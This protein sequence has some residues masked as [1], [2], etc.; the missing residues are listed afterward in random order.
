MN[1]NNQLYVAPTDIPGALDALQV[2]AASDILAF[3][4]EFD[5]EQYTYGFTLCLLQLA[6]PEIVVLI[7][8][9]VDNL[10]P[11]FMQLL[12]QSKAIKL[13]H[14]A[15]EDIRLLHALGVFPEQFE[16]TEIYARW[17]N[18]ENTSLSA[19]LQTYCG[20]ALDKDQQRSN[21]TKRPLSEKQL[22]YAQQDVVHL[23]GLRS[24]LREALEGKGLLQL[25]EE[26]IAVQAQW[27]YDETPAYPFVKPADYSRYSPYD[28]H[29]FNGMMGLR[30]A[31][32]QKL[33]RPLHF[34]APEKLMKE[35]VL[36]A[37]DLSL[38]WQDRAV[39]AATKKPA[40]MAAWQKRL[41]AL[42]EEAKER[43]LSKQLLGNGRIK[44][45]SFAE[46]RSYEKDI[47]GPI[48]KALEQRFGTFTARYILSNRIVSSIIKGETS[49][50]GLHHPLKLQ[51]I[52][53][54]ASDLQIDITPWL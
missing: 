15:G 26:D 24:K 28:L 8:P 3:D 32:A 18:L 25:A 42:H 38:L 48:Q 31:L 37:N 13:A 12:R 46:L 49:L 16:D 9:F 5:R 54:E 14:S 50:E 44:G 23:F 17:L 53:K 36:E 4:I 41:T 35:A 52:Q 40:N 33:N 21:W 47:F 1:T 29:V 7:D 27:R 51:L 34:V 20:V 19:L 39:H 6:S 10:L 2:L 43:L 30:D 11:P 45:M 22:A